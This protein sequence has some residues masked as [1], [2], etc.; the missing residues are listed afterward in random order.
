MKHVCFATGGPNYFKGVQA[1]NMIELQQTGIDQ[2]T[3]VY[4]LSITNGLNYSQAA[5]ELGACIMHMQA[6]NGEI[7]NRTRAEAREAGDTAPVFQG[8]N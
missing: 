4:G 5:Q 7:D 2:F 3:V 1:I 8:V 6:C